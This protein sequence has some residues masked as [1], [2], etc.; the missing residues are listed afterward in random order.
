MSRL[1]PAILATAIALVA[2]PARA[3]DASDANDKARQLYA[4][5]KAEYDLGHIT[6]ALAKFEAAYRVRPVP[7]LLF[8][9]AQC[10]RLLGDLNSAAMTYR[11]FLR[12]D[13]NS[14]RAAQATELLHQ[15]EEA[16]DRQQTAQHAPPLGLTQTQEAESKAALTPAV[17]APPAEKTA[18]PAA[19]WPAAHKPAPAAATSTAPAPEPAQP[20]RRLWSYVA[21]GAAVAAVAGGSL[22][23]LK[24]KSAASDLQSTP[25]ERADLDKLEPQIRSDASK[26]TALLVAGGVLAA[27]AAA[28]WVMEF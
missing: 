27:A 10:H 23:A 8:N 13:P 9:I 18:A 28:L 19:G 2:A 12:N 6:G 20:R 15:V 24:A 5:G 1:V 17:P 16:M 22:F 25:H 14:P 7:A 26:G 3:D 21:G 11:A 4:E